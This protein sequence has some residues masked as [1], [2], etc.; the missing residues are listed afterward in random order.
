M[1]KALNLMIP[2]CIV[3]GIVSVPVN[4]VA[5]DLPNV[6]IIQGGSHNLPDSNSMQAAKSIMDMAK[7]LDK[8]D[9]LM[10]LITGGGSALFPLPRPGQ[11]LM[12]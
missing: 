12:I 11:T 5:P 4:S 9:I 6:R 3:D 7:S 1:V 2:G 10:A 8:N